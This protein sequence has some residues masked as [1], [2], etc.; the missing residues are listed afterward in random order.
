MDDVLGT[1]RNINTGKKEEEDISAVYTP[2]GSFLRGAFSKKLFQ[3]V[4]SIEIREFRESNHSIPSQTS[5]IDP[6]KLDK[7]FERIKQE[8]DDRMKSTSTRLTS[9][10]DIAQFN[11]YTPSSLQYIPQYTPQYAPQYAPQ[12]PSPGQYDYRGDYY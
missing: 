11:P 8:L 10:S 7:S 9:A 6:G 3:V 5:I 1:D 12:Y 4:E 2:E